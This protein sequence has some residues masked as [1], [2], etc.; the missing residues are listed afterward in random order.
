MVRSPPDTENLEKGPS[1]QT[2]KAPAWFQFPAK[3]F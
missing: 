1:V 3:Y 2:V